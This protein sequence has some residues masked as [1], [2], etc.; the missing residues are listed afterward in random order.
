VNPRRNPWERWVLVPTLLWTLLG[1]VIVAGQARAFHETPPSVA[2][3]QVVLEE[4]PREVWYRGTEVHGRAFDCDILQSGQLSR[5]RYEQ[6]RSVNDGGAR[7]EP[8]HPARSWEDWLA[9]RGEVH[10]SWLIEWG[11]ASWLGVHHP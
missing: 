6:T 1:L 3:C 9:Y 7:L 4:R 10:P 5:A 11:E 8:G 2:E